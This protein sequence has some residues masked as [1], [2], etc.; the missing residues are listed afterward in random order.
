MEQSIITP[1]QVIEIAFS[2]GGYMSPD[3]IAKDDI[4]TAIE[5]W[6]KPVVGGP[7]LEAAA[8]G[9]YEALK[10]EYLMPVVA[11]YTRLLV[12]PRLNAVSS[13]LG[14]AVGVN[15]LSKAAEQSLRHEHI[16]A[17]RDRAH[18]ALKSLS[19]YLNTHADEFS[20]YKPKDNILNRCSC[21]GGIVQI[22]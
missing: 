8:A 5:R 22:F 3:V 15:T 4:A 16:R 7:L 14:L 6:V 19:E 2:D 20:E 13:Q 11:F 17:I 10:S 18:T 21:D 1:Q 12:Q 9:E